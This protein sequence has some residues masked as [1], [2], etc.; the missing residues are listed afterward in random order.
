[1]SARKLDHRQRRLFSARPVEGP[2]SRLV[3]E[4]GHPTEHPPTIASARAMLRR[5]RTNRRSASILIP[6]LRRQEVPPLPHSAVPIL[7]SQKPGG[8]RNA[9]APTPTSP[10]SIGCAQATEPSHP[11]RP[12]L[13][14]R[15]AKWLQAIL[16]H[17]IRRIPVA[18]E[19]RFFARS[20][21]VLSSRPSTLEGA[22]LRSSAQPN[23]RAV[24]GKEAA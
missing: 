24:E 7:P 2:L 14:S 20:R 8:A 16:R 18:T 5:E 15:F 9:S 13:P 19:C 12:E 10:A 21:S 22:R 4:F 1:M 3:A 11:G 23:R 17:C 6:G